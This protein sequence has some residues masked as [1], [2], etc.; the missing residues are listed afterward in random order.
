MSNAPAL[1]EAMHGALCMLL[2]F[3]VAMFV[4]FIVHELLLAGYRMRTQAAI[5]ILVL[6]TGETVLRGWFWLWQRQLN[7]GLSIEWMSAWPVVPI[8]LAIEMVGVLCL[9]RV[10]QPDH[11]H[12]FTW[13]GVGLSAAMLSLAIAQV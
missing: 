13:L 8:G 5:S 6:I 12:R 7:D 4:T 9:I 3:A 10:F 1:V 11:W 2:L